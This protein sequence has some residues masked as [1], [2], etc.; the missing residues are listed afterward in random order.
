MVI[1]FSDPREKL[2]AELL[3]EAYQRFPEKW[4][5]SSELKVEPG[6]IINGKRNLLVRC[7]YRKWLAI[8]HI[9]PGKTKY[10]LTDSGER[11]ARNLCIL[12]G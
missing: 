1:T 8:S 12:H 2:Y 9:N 11:I 10:K 6:D 3:M 4:F 7:M 5:A